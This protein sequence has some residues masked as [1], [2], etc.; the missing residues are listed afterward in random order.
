MIGA[1]QDVWLIQTASGILQR[2][3][4]EAA[5]KVGPTWSPDGGRIVFSWDPQGVLDLYEKPV[6]SRGDATLLLSSPESKAATDW[7]KDGRF[8]L[9]GS[10]GFQT[11]NDVW[12]LPLMGDRKPLEV[13][14]TT[15]SE[16]GG[17]FSPDSRWVAYQSNET[18]RNEIYVQPFPGPGGKKQ[19]TSGGGAGVQWGRD[20]RT[21]SYQAANRVMEVPITIDGPSVEAGKPV[22][23]FTLPP[24]STYAASH[25]GER[26]L[27][28][29]VVK[30]ASPITLLL[31]W[32]PR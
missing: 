12:A 29:K 28:S 7:S 30:E 16:A 8:V 4:F 25:D 23:L 32:K 27:V 3:T 9:Y 10:F 31:N 19:I 1:Y 24:G 18:G 2:F 11:R 15:F 6:D 13:A 26:F 14:H 22:T 21:L 20:G 17:R 5:N